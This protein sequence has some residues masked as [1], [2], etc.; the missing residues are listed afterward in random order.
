MYKKILFLGII[1]FLNGLTNVTPL[2]LLISV[3]QFALVLYYILN[4]KIERAIFWHF[5]FFITSFTYYGD[6]CTT[7]AAISFT[8]YNY[9]KLKLIG[10]IGFSQI[11]AI[12]LF[13]TVLMRTSVNKII[14]KPFYQFY[15]L[16]RYLLITGFGIG[17][18]G[19]AFD[20][21]YFMGVLQYGS[22]IIIIYIHTYILYKIN[23]TILRKDFFEIVIPVLVL[24]PICTFVL[25]MINPGLEGGAAASFY[26]MLLI[27]ALLF[28]KKIL[29]VLVGLFFIIY[30]SIFF[31][32][33]GKTL[34]MF[35]LFI[36]ITFL[37]TF[38]KNIKAKFLYRAKIFRAIC[39]IFFLLIPTIMLIIDDKFDGSAQISSK[40]YQ[41][42]TLMEFIFFEGGL[43]YIS[44]SPYIRVT[45]LINILYE[46]IKNPIILLFGR[47]F[48]GYFNDH[49]N[50]F[51]GMDLSK[52]AFSDI[53]INSGDYYSGHDTMVTLPMF[54]GIIGF[55]FLLKVLI[56]YL[57][58]SR[59]NYIALSV[60][61]FLIL[62][63]Y[64]DALI[65]VTGVLLLFVSTH[66]DLGNE[67]INYEK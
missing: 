1:I 58:L 14:N 20:H 65:G 26:S 22:Y 43:Q 51:S 3:P 48:G 62:A 36:L 4:N 6:D 59:I 42:K 8:S 45:S 15:K 19:F 33:S 55:Y 18:I 16:I 64:Y 7:G 56:E 31:N 61:P 11:I 37:L 17:L 25:K 41:T 60:I 50:Y 28:N 24:F 52:G 54:N 44:N 40:I 23:N 35:L 47:G 21:Y 66:S 13:A 34:I 2:N 49:L 57:K 10:P 63:F 29:F 32:T 9:A 5:M 46:G 27:P 12:L 38:N 53:E 39:L 30:N 67:K